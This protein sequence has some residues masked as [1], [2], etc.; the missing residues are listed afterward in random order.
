[1]FQRFFVEKNLKM[2]YYEFKGILYKRKG[3]N[4]VKNKNVKKHM[5]YSNCCDNYVFKYFSVF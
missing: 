1:M 3:E 4:Y 5:D 2:Y